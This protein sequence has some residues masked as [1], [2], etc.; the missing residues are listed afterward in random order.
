MDDEN[1]EETIKEKYGQE[2]LDC[3]LEIRSG[4]NDVIVQIHNILSK[5]YIEKLGKES[6][7]TAFACVLKTGFCDFFLEAIKDKPLKE[8]SSSID[9]VLQDAFDYMFNR[10]QENKK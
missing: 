7:Y 5:K 3:M 9:T 10:L 4:V 2:T 1:I 6:Y 8:I